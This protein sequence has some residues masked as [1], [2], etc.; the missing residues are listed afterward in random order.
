MISDRLVN[1]SAVCWSPDDRSIAMVTGPI[2]P[3]AEAVGP[4]GWPDQAYTLF[5]VDG[6]TQLDIPA[7]TVDGT[8]ACSWQRLAP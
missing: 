8:H 3:G 4:S 6:G 5:P 2:P 1:V 7:G